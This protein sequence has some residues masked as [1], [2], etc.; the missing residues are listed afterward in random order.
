MTSEANKF[1][2]GTSPPN[3]K[4][5]QINPEDA[6]NYWD[7]ETNETEII[8]SIDDLLVDLGNI[9]HIWWDLLKIFHLDIIS[10]RKSQK[11]EKKSADSSSLS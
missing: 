11:F 4:K 7:E 8:K 6:L 9:R 3:M 1:E 10:A 5:E 2:F